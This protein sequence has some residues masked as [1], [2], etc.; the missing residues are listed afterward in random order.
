MAGRHASFKAH[1]NDVGLGAGAVSEGALIRA[2]VIT[3][4]MPWQSKKSRPG[5]SSTKIPSSRTNARFLLTCMEEMSCMSG[6]KY[7]YV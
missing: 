2:G 3:A 6:S 1:E 7:V 5:M 4:N